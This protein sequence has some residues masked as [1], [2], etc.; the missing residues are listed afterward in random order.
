M[1]MLQTHGASPMKQ[2]G[3][4]SESYWKVDPTNK[5]EIP[6]KSILTILLIVF[7]V[8]LVAQEIPQLLGNIRHSARNSDG[9]LHVRWEDISEVAGTT[10]FYYSTNGGSWNTAT[11]NPFTFGVMESLVPYNYGQS[12]RYRLH[13]EA[14]T[15][16]IGRA[17]V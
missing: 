8:S 1:L 7:C 12:L 13:M 15:P 10:S 6:M 16:E 5:K 2:A 9:Y 3:P 4:T 14:S 11:V 17:H